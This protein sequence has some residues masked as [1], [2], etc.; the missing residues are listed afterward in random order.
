MFAQD[1]LISAG[2]QLQ[3]FLKDARL[4]FELN[5]DVET[6]KLFDHSTKVPN[7]PLHIQQPSEIVDVEMQIDDEHEFVHHASIQRSP[8]VLGMLKTPLSNKADSTN[9]H[10]LQ[11]TTRSKIDDDIAKVIAKVCIW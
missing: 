9:S 10:Q 2:E 5:P 3:E 8:R 4:K 1:F 11:A 7:R 6:H